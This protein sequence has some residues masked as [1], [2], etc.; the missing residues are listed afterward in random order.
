M[1]RGSV[2]QRRFP[3]YQMSF[4]DLRGERKEE[5]GE[6]IEGMENICFSFP[7][8]RTGTFRYQQCNV[9]WSWLAINGIMSFGPKVRRSWKGAADYQK[10]SLDLGAKFAQSNPAGSRCMYVRMQLCHSL[11]SESSSN[12]K[13]PGFN[14]SK[15][16]SVAETN[17]TLAI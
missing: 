4:W 10:G 1:L 8:F 3:V 17:P 9:I 6:R 11:W 12:A 16:G 7:D 2:S 14:D 15:P 13:F 5:T